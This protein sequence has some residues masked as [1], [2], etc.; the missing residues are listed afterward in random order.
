[1]KAVNVTM[2][3]SKKMGYEDVITDVYSGT[4]LLPNVNSNGCFVAKLHPETGSKEL[5]DIFAPFG[6][7]VNA[8]VVLDEGTQQSK[9]YGFVNYTTSEAAALAIQALHGQPNCS[10]PNAQALIVKIKHDKPR[11]QQH[12]Q[13][14]ASY[15]QI[16]PKST[17][18]VF[19]NNHQIYQNQP[20][21]M[22][23]SPSPSPVR[24]PKRRHSD[25]QNGVQKSQAPTIYQVQNT[26]KSVVEQE[27]SVIQHIII[28][29]E[30]FRM[31]GASL[32][33]VKL[34]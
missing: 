28:P 10:A 31:I 5:A 14:A 12:M 16:Y 8:R 22:R 11:A 29:N 2:H 19:H 21:P 15:T 30:S 9:C 7:I 20:A 24:V 23:H 25:Y 13:S 32:E 26:A 33:K 17:G 18:E 4:T 6:T 34:R 27:E 1:M 3:Q